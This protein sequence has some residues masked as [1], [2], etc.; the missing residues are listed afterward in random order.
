MCG[1]VELQNMLF[2]IAI[3]NDFDH[4]IAKGY[5]SFGVDVFE[6]RNTLCRRTK[7]KF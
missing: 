5:D 3:L 2:H 4:A 1:F 7:F 6:L